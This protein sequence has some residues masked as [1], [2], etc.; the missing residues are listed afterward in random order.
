MVYRYYQDR[1]DVILSWKSDLF[2]INYN[3]YSFIYFGNEISFCWQIKIFGKF[4]TLFVNQF[5]R[6]F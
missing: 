3:V 2:S 5:P 1:W 4:V 6:L